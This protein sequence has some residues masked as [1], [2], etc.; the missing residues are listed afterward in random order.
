MNFLWSI[1]KC[2]FTRFF[3]KSN[4]DGLQIG[5]STQ[6]NSFCANVIVTTVKR[7]SKKWLL[8]VNL[9]LF[10]LGL[11]FLIADDYIQLHTISN[12]IH[13]LMIVAASAFF[14]LKF[15]AWKLSNDKNILKL[16][17]IVCASFVGGLVCI[18][19]IFLIAYENIAAYH[20]WRGF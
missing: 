20:F 6:D 18:T 15:D 13:I 9:T 17:Y 2:N 8:P 5:Y 1:F 19:Y 4:D 16:M 3:P 14:V 12:T 11:L 10:L 7:K